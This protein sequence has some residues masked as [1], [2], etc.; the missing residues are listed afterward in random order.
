MDNDSYK[1]KIT[2]RKIREILYQ[3][4]LTTTKSKR[5]IWEIVAD[6]AEVILNG[7]IFTDGLWKDER[8]AVEKLFR[9]DTKNSKSSSG[10]VIMDKTDDWKSREAITIR[11]MAETENV[12][13]QINNA[14]TMEA[15]AILAAAQILS[16]YKSDASVTTDCKGKQDKINLSYPESWANHGQS[17]ILRAIHLLYKQKINWTRSHPE[18]RKKASEYDKSDFRIAMADALCE[19]ELRSST[20]TQHVKTMMEEIKYLKIYYYEITMEDVLKE[21]LSCLPFAWTKEKIP[22]IV[23][24]QSLRDISRKEKYLEK[25]D[26]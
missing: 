10:V 19:G 25:R 17:Q 24:L 23:Q 14:F 5:S 9:I 6:H 7:T 16:W 13:E 26:Q 3:N 22:I 11:I 4:T 18:L 1:Y 15:T 8:S 20:R 21:M 2:T 12:K